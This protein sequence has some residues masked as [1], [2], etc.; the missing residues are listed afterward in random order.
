MSLLTVTH[1]QRGG[2]ERIKV[3]LCLAGL[4]VPAMPCGHGGGDRVAGV[5]VTPCSTELPSLHP[6]ARHRDDANFGR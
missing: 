6:S 1:L 4:A 5:E 2:G 3:K